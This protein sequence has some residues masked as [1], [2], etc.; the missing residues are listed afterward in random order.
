MALSH[1]NAMPIRLLHCS[2]HSE[3][4]LLFLSVLGVEHEMAHVLNSWSPAS[5]AT[6]TGCGDLEGGLPTGEACSSVLLQRKFLVP[7]LSL[8]LRFCLQQ[9]PYPRIL[10]TQ[11]YRLYLFPLNGDLGI[12][13]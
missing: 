11:R 9:F 8:S 10:T 5:G 6:L 4:V 13:E 3:L 7:S 12:I 2:L 1:Q